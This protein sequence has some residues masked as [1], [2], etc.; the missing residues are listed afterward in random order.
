[1]TKQCFSVISYFHSSW[2]FEV[3]PRICSCSATCN[4]IG[5][6]WV[7]ISAAFW[8]EVDT[9]LDPAKVKTSVLHPVASTQNL[10]AGQSQEHTLGPCRGICSWKIC[11]YNCI[12]LQ[13]RLAKRMVRSHYKSIFIGSES[14]LRS[15][16]LGY[17]DT[18]R[19]MLGRGF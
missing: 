7:A 16:G 14:K 19:R 10:V 9:E 11:W 3:L 18:S 12:T 17:L 8:F 5:H 4:E 15:N 13:I 1:M 6:F 2:K